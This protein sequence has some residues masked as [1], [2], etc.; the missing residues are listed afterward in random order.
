VGVLYVRI[1]GLLCLLLL[2]L[3]FRMAGL[4]RI[5]FPGYTHD[6]LM[7]IIQ[8]RLEGVPGDIVDADAVQFA[9]RKVAAVSGDARRALDICRRAVEIAE[10]EAL[11]ITEE[12]EDDDEDD[13]ADNVFGSLLPDTPSKTGRKFQRQVQQ[14]QQQQQRR[15][16]PAGSGIRGRVTIATVK[17]AISEATSSPLQQHLRNLPLAAKLFLAAVLARV[18]RTGVRESV[19]GDVL[20]EAKHI[21]KMADAAAAPQL[22][23][24]L[25]TDTVVVSSGGG[26]GG[27]SGGGGGGG[28]GSG[29]GS[30]GGGGRQNAS[31][32]YPA[33]PGSRHQQQQQQQ[34]Q[35]HYYSYHFQAPRPLGM[36]AAAAELADAG[37]IGLE[38]RR[39]DRALKM[40][41]NVSEDEVKLAFRDDPEVR[42]FGLSH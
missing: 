22:H 35:Q 6:Q 11:S 33:P 27:G 7:A 42:G 10:S 41:L 8:S 23:A 15:R 40:R 30:G 25:L 39:A 19:L 14:Q 12:E 29:G 1:Y 13:D 9:S 24:F 32:D 36:A 4:T 17:Q 38:A 16:R 20:D 28:G 31:A 37:I 2:S 3:F 26:G 5:T 34:Q 21:G 18:R